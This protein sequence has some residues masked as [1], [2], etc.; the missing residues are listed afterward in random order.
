MLVMPAPVGGGEEEGYP[1]I[2][3]MYPWWPY[4]PRIYTPVCLPGSTSLIPAVL[5]SG[6]A[7]LGAVCTPV[8]LTLG[9]TRGW[10]SPG[11]LPVLH[12][13]S[14]DGRVMPGSFRCYR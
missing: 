1:Y 9:E 13:V 10:E 6:A 2:P 7:L 8:W 4:Y 12:P 14:V 5:V 11:D 3:T